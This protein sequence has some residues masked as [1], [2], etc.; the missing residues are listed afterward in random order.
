MKSDKR[1]GPVAGFDKFPRWLAKSPA[2][3]DLG[4]VEVKLLVY[5]AHVRKWDGDTSPWTTVQE[6]AEAVG[7][8]RG[9]VSRALRNLALLGAVR[10]EHSN[11]ASRNRRTRIRLMFTSPY[12]HDQKGQEAR[13][14]PRCLE[15]QAP[16]EIWTESDHNER[17]PGANTVQ[18]RS[19]S[20]EDELPE[21]AR[22]PATVG[23]LQ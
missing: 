23:A 20:G 13:C 18:N 15:G 2:F 22:E 21:W 7:A 16:S 17:I 9:G 12:D 4:G 19:I 14:S 8:R 10:V 11:K 1:R 5:F 3:K 6:L